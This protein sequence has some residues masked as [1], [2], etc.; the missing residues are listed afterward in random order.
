MSDLI[1]A[2]ERKSADETYTKP[3]VRGDGGIVDPADH[4]IKDAK[5]LIEIDFRLELTEDKAD[6]AMGEE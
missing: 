3:V 4:V 6:A 5:D 1:L 2:E